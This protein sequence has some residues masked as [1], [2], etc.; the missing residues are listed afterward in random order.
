VLLAYRPPEEWDAYIRRNGLKQYTPN[1]VTD[2]ETLKRELRGIRRAGWAVTYQEYIPGARALGV[3][4]LDPAGTVTASVS[5]TGPGTRL[6]RQRARQLKPL[7]LQTARQISLAL[8]GE[9]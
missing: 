9:S 1:T 4:I 6:T 5:V 2:P 7:A 8:A 3:P